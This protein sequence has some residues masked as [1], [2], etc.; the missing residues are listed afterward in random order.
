MLLA[1]TG[2]LYSIALNEFIM[3]DGLESGKDDKEEQVIL[4][5][6][7]AINCL[8]AF[9]VYL[10]YELYLQLYRLRKILTDVD[11][12]YTSGW[13]QS[14]MLEQ[15]VCLIAPYPF[16][17]GYIYTEVNTTYNVTITYQINQILMCF[18]FLRVYI[19]FRYGL[20]NSSFMAPRASRM[21]NMVGCQ[22]DHM[23]AIKALM[24]QMPYSLLIV[25]LLLTIFL[26]GYQLKVF[27]GP[28][29]EA[30]G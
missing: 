15:I 14:M 6:I 2:I 8:L 27:E 24:K 4:N 25:T 7:M 18:S 16:T 10:R 23:F 30:S 22:A 11:T 28:L 1:S 12:L 3:I 9:A 29:S 5:I 26:F 17:Q 21:C 19:L 20:F 13:W